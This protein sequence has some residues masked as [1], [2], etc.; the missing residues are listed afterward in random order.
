MD[1]SY[2]SSRRLLLRARRHTRVAL[3]GGAALL[4]AIGISIWTWEPEPIAASIP[5]A[6]T[7]T[8]ALDA[9]PGSAGEEVRGVRRI[10]PYSVV[11]GGVA[12]QAQLQRV[13]RT[14]RVVAAHYASFDAR[15]ARPIVVDKPRAVHV[16]YRKGDQVFWTAHKVTLSPGE[17]LLSDGQNEMRARCAN[18]ISDLPQYPVE[19]HRPAV[20]ELDQ[21]IELA[22][23][24][25]FAL[26]AGELPA[27]MEAAGGMR[28]HP[29][30]SLAPN[31]AGAAANAARPGTSPLPANT[32]SEPRNM[33]PVSTV[34]LLGYSGSKRNSPVGETGPAAGT[35]TSGGSSGAPAP[36]PDG[37]TPGGAPAGVEP[38]TSPAPDTSTTPGTPAPTPGF[39][40]PLPAPLPTPLPGTT[41][42]PGPV[43]QPQ[44]T[45]AAPTPLPPAPPVP[46]PEPV[47]PKPTPEPLPSQ[48]IVPP[49]PVEVP[50][51]GSLWLFGLVLVAMRVLR[52]R[53]SA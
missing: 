11:P 2:P 13:I 15:K 14:D 42:T 53:P 30:M 29:A 18:R 16:S 50:E 7:A 45:L 22:E 26:V 24:E 41:P 36:S 38:V 4:G 21:P 40:A 8:L 35:G 31:Q 19:A 9:A 39:E 51:P 3:V 28:Q 49:A 20:E 43:P 1:R 34:N 48:T 6:Y 37:G 27:G 10:Y 52:R 32:F 12:T 44:P 47:L 23:E 25:Q 17:T 5:A 33:G 46:V